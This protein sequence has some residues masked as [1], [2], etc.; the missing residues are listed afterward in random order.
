MECLFCKSKN[1]SECNIK[2]EGK[3]YGVLVSDKNKKNKRRLE[4]LMCNECGM[5][6]LKVCDEDK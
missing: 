4:S 2:V 5:V 3:I 6:F 1:I